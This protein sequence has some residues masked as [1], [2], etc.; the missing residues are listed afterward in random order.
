MLAIVPRE[1]QPLVKGSKV[2]TARTKQSINTRRKIGRTLAGARFTSWTDRW[3]ATTLL[4]ISFWDD[5]G[6][7]ECV[8]SLRGN[9]SHVV[10]TEFVRLGTEE[11]AVVRRSVWPRGR[12]IGEVPRNEDLPALETETAYNLPRLSGLAKVEL[13]IPPFARRIPADIDGYHS[14]GLAP[15]ARAGAKRAITRPARPGQT[16]AARASV[17]SRSARRSTLPVG[18][19]GSSSRIVISSGTL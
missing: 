9:L 7:A 10:P 18:P 13:S 11:R 8:P 5:P 4:L 1:T 15:A 2:Y 14:A 3:S 17:A 6:C 19:L 16:P 12:L